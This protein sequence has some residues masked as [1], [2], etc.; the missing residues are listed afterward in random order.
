LKENS[1]LV[2]CGRRDVIPIMAT[3]C[4]AVELAPKWLLSPTKRT[5]FANGE[6][7]W[8]FFRKPRLTVVTDIFKWNSSTKIAFLGRVTVY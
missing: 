6:Y 7:L 1:S 4:A 8:K 5:E 3:R 2:T